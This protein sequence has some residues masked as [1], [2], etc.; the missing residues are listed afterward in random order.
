MPEDQTL[1]AH[2]DGC[3]CDACLII[4]TEQ[5]QP[6][7]DCSACWLMCHG[8]DDTTANGQPMEQST[9][10][11]M[12]PS[13]EQPME[14]STEQPTEQ[15]MEPSTEQP[16]WSRRQNSRWSCRQ[17]SRWNRRQSI[18]PQQ[19]ALTHSEGLAPKGTLCVST[20][21]THTYTHYTI[22]G[23]GLDM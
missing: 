4:A 6:G 21:Q 9:E 20:L 2:K 12:E 3:C 22:L 17:N 1:Q 23:H 13:T 14:P 11:P 7:C 5:H 19:A 16:M 18:A 8:T 15:P 10:Q